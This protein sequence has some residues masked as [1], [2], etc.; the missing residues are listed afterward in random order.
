MHKPHADDTNTENILILTDSTASLPEQVR[1][2]SHLD[3]INLHV[4]YDTYDLE[5]NAHITPQQ[6][7]ALIADKKNL[8]TSQP[9]KQ[10]FEDAYEHALKNGY[11]AVVSI[12]ISAALS[13]T[14]DTACM[15][16]EKFGDRVRVLNSNTTGM[17]LGFLALEGARLSAQGTPIQELIDT[18]TARA[19]TTGAYF[20]VDSLDHLRRGGRLSAAAAAVGTVLGVKPILHV[21]ETGHI[22]V[23]AKVRSRAH[24][25]HYL[26]EQARNAQNKGAHEFAVHYFGDE[27]RAHELAQRLHTELDTEIVVTP[28]SAVLGSH[29]GPG[30]IAL[31]YA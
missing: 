16:A 6:C 8:T 22:E 28:V 19:H 2:N 11:D 29:V 27:T 14:Y 31:T 30:L 13:G 10:A 24:V 3:V 25:A 17:A 20:A 18:M 21:N 9:S 4:L 12:H 5:E 23:A 1:Q 15:A 7:A 26:S